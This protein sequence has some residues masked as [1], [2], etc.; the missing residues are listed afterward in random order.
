MDHKFIDGVPPPLP[1]AARQTNSW[2]HAIQV[3]QSKVFSPSQAS[4]AKVAATRKKHTQKGWNYISR[5]NPDGTVTI[6]RTA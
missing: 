3:G 2:V 1:R 4:T 5:Q 6:W